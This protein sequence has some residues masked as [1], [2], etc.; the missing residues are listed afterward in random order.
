LPAIA[1]EESETVLY[2]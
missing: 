1:K 2:F